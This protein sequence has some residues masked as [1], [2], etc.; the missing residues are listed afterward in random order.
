MRESARLS[1]INTPPIRR[2]CA[3]DLPFIH[4]HLALDIARRRRYVCGMSSVS[5]PGIPL[6][7]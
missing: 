4:R 5:G 7:V 1:G 2:P 3:A 6:I